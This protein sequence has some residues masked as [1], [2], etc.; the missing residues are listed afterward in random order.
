MLT[1]LKCAFYRIDLYSPFKYESEVLKGPSSTSYQPP[2]RHLRPCSAAVRLID[3]DSFSFALDF[4]MIR[5]S[6]QRLEAKEGLELD[7]FRSLE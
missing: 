1:I 2:A 3:L 7:M 5:F 4:S 6:V